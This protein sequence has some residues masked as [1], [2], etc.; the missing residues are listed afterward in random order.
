MYNVVNPDDIVDKY[1]ADTL[2]LY[3]MFLGPLEQSKPWDTNGI[4]GVHRFL[5]RAWGLF[6]NNEQFKV[7]ND[8]PE[9]AALKSLHK[10]IQKISY[11]IEHFSFNTS[12]SAFMICVNE[13]TTLKCNNSAILSEFLILLS[14]FA[15]HIAE[16][17]WNA[18]GNT[19]TIF[20]AEWP[21]L[22]EEYLREDTF[23]YAISFN[24]KVRYVLEFS[25]E[26][27]NPEIEETV[28]SHVNSEKWLKGKTPKKIII[29][30]RKIVN[31]VV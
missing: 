8:E 9:L 12:V 29:V 25:A 19:E 18:L 10:L 26:A 17:L 11:D 1:G 21:V 23:K 20:D 6:Y 24:G 14:P 30:P 28:L 3:E 4:D 5:R 15:P 2:R 7:S 13:L 22:N 16:E 31:V 27:T